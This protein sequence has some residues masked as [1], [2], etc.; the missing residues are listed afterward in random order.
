MAMSLPPLFRPWYREDR[1]F[2]KNSEACIMFQELPSHCRLAGIRYDLSVSTNTSIGLDVHSTFQ[3]A[4]Y[5]LPAHGTDAAEV[6]GTRAAMYTYAKRFI[7]RVVSEIFHTDDAG[8]AN[9]DTWIPT[10][11]DY[12]VQQ[13]QADTEF[14]FDLVRLPLE[15]LARPDSFAPIK[16]W[17]P[18]LGWQKQQAYRHGEMSKCYGLF[19]DQG[20]IRRGITLGA[21]PGYIAW[22]LTNPDNVSDSE[23]DDESTHHVRNLEFENLRGLAPMRDLIDG[24]TTI[25][26]STRLDMLGFM[27]GVYDTTG[28]RQRDQQAIDYNFEV[29]Y[30]IDRAARDTRVEEASVTS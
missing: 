22:I 27:Q 12:V 9:T 25:L 8:T 3:L 26:P 20:I 6:I 23:W 29:T 13:N 21:Q 4:G 16:L 30:Y 28:T 2:A 5:Y 19:T 7:P 24:V 17:R 10:E 18:K 11:S 14:S 15:L 1:N